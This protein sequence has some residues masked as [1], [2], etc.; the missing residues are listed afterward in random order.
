MVHQHNRDRSDMSNGWLR[1]ARIALYF[2]LGIIAFF[3]ITEHFAHLIP[4]LPLAISP[5]LSAHA[6][7]YARWTWRTWWRQ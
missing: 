4:V 3:L 5:S 7:I 2:F 6:S 1:P